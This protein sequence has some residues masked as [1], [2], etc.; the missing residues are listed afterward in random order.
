VGRE[1][2]VA[3]PYYILFI[4]IAFV[5]AAY[6]FYVLI[7]AL[8]LKPLRV[9]RRLESVAAGIKPDVTD[10]RTPGDGDDNLPTVAKL[11]S[12]RGFADKLL[13]MLQRAG[14]KLRP[15]EFIGYIA[16]VSI[17]LVLLVSVIYPSFWA[18][19][20]AMALG[21]FVPVVY[22]RV[23]QARR[24]AAFDRQLP[25]ALTMISSAIRS[26][27]SFLRAMQMVAEEMP[28]PISEEF[29]RALNEVNVGLPL[30]AALNRMVVRVQSYDLEL[31]VTA[32]LV[33]QQIGGNLAEVLENISSTIRDRVRVEGE[34][35]ALT[36]EGR[37][38]GLILVIMPFVMAAIIWSLNPDYLRILIIEP[39]GKWLI[40][41]GL[42][43]QGIGAL[44]IKRMLI[45]DY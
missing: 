38:S 43:L 31:V 41:G 42:T 7:D 5:A 24:L 44:I 17:V 3:L 32:V 45:L 12:S 28:V 14:L 10:D 13:M 8:W 30:D 9:R 19:L 33:Q 26:G 36:A 40:I 11:L 27:Y 16:G 23:L 20:T 39:W 35:A 21:V 34:L 37:L 6:L 29:Q 25:D 2:E 18:I 15:S 4:P 1:E 22:I